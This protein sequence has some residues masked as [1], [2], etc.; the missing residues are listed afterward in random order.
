MAMRKYLFASTGSGLSTPV[1]FSLPGSGLSLPATARLKT[2]ENTDVA[3]KPGDYLEIARSTSS[4]GMVYMVA[5][6]VNSPSNPTFLEGCFRVN[7]PV[8]DTTRFLLSS[9]TEDFFLGTCE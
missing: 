6:E 4:S 7:D 1:E 9:G 3:L 5:L 8:T 2:W